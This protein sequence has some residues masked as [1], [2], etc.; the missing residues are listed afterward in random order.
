MKRLTPLFI[1]MILLS[2]GTVYADVDCEI[3]KKSY[4]TGTRRLIRIT[5]TIQATDVIAVKECIENANNLNSLVVILNSRGGDVYAG[6]E[7]GRLLRKNRLDVMVPIPAQCMSSC[8]LV[9]VGSVDRMIYGK[10]GIHRPYSTKTGV[11]GFEDAQS[12]YQKN[13]SDIKNYLNEMNITS[14]I[15]DAMERI[16]PEKI[17]ILTTKEVDEFGL[18]DIDPV[19]QEVRDANEADLRGISKQEYLRRVSEGSQ[20]CWNDKAVS[21]EEIQN[22]LDCENAYSWGLITSVYKE[23]YNKTFSICRE[24]GKQFGFNSNEARK[25]ERE[26]ML[27]VR[28]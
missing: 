1:F 20:V 21:D 23:R 27:G 10:I 28:K 3:R 25:C 15:F 4:G 26:V 24:V 5:G 2:I 22:I 12:Q 18:D 16:P 6:M 19:E 9:L 13:R 8:V 14:S 11:I 17:R 7:L